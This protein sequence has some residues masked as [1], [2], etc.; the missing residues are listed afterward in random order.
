MLKE[1]TTL[2]GVSGKEGA[3]REYIQNK[4][5][6]FVD[7]ISVDKMGNLIVLKKGKS[8]EKRFMICAH[9]DEV[10]LL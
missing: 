9:M 8:S 5:V 2:N 6:P 3:V 1:L 4:I 7:E 10:G